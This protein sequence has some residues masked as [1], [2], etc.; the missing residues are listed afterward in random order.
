[1]QFYIIQSSFPVNAFAYYVDIPH[2]VKSDLFNFFTCSENLKRLNE[3]AFDWKLAE[4][5]SSS[6]KCNS[7]LVPC[8]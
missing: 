8:T 5:H 7:V 4:R 3:L 6:V 1:M 2:A